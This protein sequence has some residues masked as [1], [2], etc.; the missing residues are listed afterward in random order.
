MKIL[1]DSRESNPLEFV[2]TDGVEFVKQALP[3]GD[4]TAEGQSVVVERKS[5]AD[6]FGS[7]SKGYEAERNKI[8]KANT[9]NLKYILAIEGTLF[10]VREGHKYWKDGKE[11]TCKADGHS[12]IKRLMTITRKYGVEVHFFNGRKEM[13][14][15]IVEYF[16]AFERI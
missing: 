4:Y 2:G 3:V 12:M 16:L 13:A 9:R 15:W 11:H 10:E 1:V 7:F 14:H 5:I 8:I 6:L